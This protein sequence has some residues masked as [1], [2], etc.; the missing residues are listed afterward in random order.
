MMVEDL[1][2]MEALLEDFKIS[3]IAAIVKRKG[4]KPRRPLKKA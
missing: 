1:N 2:N 4:R 3:N